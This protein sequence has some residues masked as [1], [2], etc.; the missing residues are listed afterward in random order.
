M[1]DQTSEYY[2]IPYLAMDVFGEIISYMKKLKILRNCMLVCN[3][4]HNYIYHGEY[5][6]NIPFSIFFL[7]LF[8]NILTYGDETTIIHMQWTTIK[9]EELL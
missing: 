9:T 7:Q 6:C 2:E 3:E 5:H 8:D 4:W 1:S